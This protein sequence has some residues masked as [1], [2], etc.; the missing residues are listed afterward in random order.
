MFRV[1]TRSFAPAN[2]ASRRQ[3]QLLG[4]QVVSLS[5]QK[6]LLEIV[7]KLL[8]I[9]GKPCELCNRVAAAHRHDDPFVSVLR[10]ADEHWLRNLIGA[11]FSPAALKV[12]IR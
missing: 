7:H 3:A 10:I 8:H 9:D 2:I 12:F 4:C 5:N 1:A 6:G 11:L